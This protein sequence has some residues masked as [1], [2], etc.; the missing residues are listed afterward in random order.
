MFYAQ[1]FT[2]FNT[3]I[4]AFKLCMMYVLKH[5]HYWTNVIYLGEI[6]VLHFEILKHVYYSVNG[7]RL[8]N[9]S[10]GAL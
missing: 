7:I 1:H 9:S 8:R 10:S 3:L 5:M 4:C 6:L 2:C